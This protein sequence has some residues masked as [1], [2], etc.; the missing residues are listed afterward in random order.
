MT[1]LDELLRP[2][3]PAAPRY[4]RGMQNTALAFVLLVLSACSSIGGVQT[5][6]S[7]REVL[8]EGATE[9]RVALAE[10][11]AFVGSGG[12]EWVG[13]GA[14]EG[15]AGEVTIGGQRVWVSAVEEG[16]L[17]VRPAEPGDRAALLVAAEVDGWTVF[18]LGPQAD[19]LALEAALGA[20]LED[21]GYRLDVPVPVRLT[22][23]AAA[24][25][26]HVIDGACPIANP[27][28]PPPFRGSYSG[29]V[30]L[31]G[32]YAE[33]RAGELTHHG[34]RTHLHAV[35]EG[36]GGTPVAAG[37]L[38]DLQLEEVSVFLPER[39]RRSSGVSFG[40]GFGAVL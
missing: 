39:P 25:D 30:T 35:V 11:G 40:V 26:L 37:H 16:K 38:D 28:G 15:L 34:R 22:G 18:S 3:A 14:L 8:K 9:G 1:S 24:L 13:V 32:V 5:W 2:T 21:E 19:L 31:V 17:S 10:D 6:G 27:D 12:S 36:E 7:M 23:R 20:L 4:A 33:G 29:R